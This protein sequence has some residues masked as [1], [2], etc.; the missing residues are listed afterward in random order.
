[1]CTLTIAWQVFDE[2]PVVVAANRDE[3]TD[4]PSDPPGTLDPGVIAPRDR[5]AGGTWVGVNNDGVFV[6]ITN[7]WVDG[8]AAERSRGL[9]VRDCLQQASAETA[10]KEVE[11]AVRAD[12][13]DGFNL[14]IAD[15]AAALLLEWDGHLRVTPFEPGVHVLVNVGADGEFFVP[16]GIPTTDSQARAETQAHNAR[17]LRAHLQ[18]RPG[19]NPD[20]WLTRAGTALGNHEFGVCLH[21]DGYGTRS[22]SLIKLSTDGTSRYEFA[23]GPPCETTYARVESQS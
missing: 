1:M 16:E 7:R 15:E 20:E 12:E 4:R 22:S 17:R 21:G 2:A 6:G 18:P 23:D 10:A 13:Y 14:V 3:S 5:E 8:L 11:S 9:L 19:E